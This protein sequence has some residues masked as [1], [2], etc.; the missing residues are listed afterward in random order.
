MRLNSKATQQC[1]MLSFSRLTTNPLYRSALLCIYFFAGKA[2]VNNIEW[3]SNAGSGPCHV[4]ACWRHQM[5]IC[6][7]LLAI[8][9]G[10]SPVPGDSPHKDQWRRALMFVF[11]LRPNKRLS[12]QWRGW[13][14]ETPSSPLWRHCKGQDI[15]DV[16]LCFLSMDPHSI[17]TN[18][19]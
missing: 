9:A 13:W 1:F 8:C 11:H 14:F 7:A 5:E 19:F 3:V 16:C 6:F 10:N 18:Q 4:T 2:R 17:V 15:F 12:K